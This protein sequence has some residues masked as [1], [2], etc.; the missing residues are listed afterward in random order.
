[1][2]SFFS[3]IITCCIAS[4]DLG[5]SSRWFRTEKCHERMRIM[6]SKVNST[7]SRPSV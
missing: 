3:S 6:S 5:M 7:I 4:S 2:I 1:M